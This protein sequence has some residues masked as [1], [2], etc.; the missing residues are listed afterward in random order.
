MFCRKCFSPDRDGVDI[1]SEQVIIFVFAACRDL[2]EFPKHCYTAQLY[3][4]FSQAHPDSVQF[5]KLREVN[6]LNKL[7]SNID[8]YLIIV[9]A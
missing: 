7:H 4:G 1:S 6:L 9:F 5:V 3:R 2:I 8:I